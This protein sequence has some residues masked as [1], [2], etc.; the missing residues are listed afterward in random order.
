MTKLSPRD[1][2]KRFQ[3][4]RTTLSKA[5]KDGTISATKTDKGHWKIDAAELS[6]VY[7]PRAT[8]T[9]I[10]RTKPDH[11]DHARPDQ[12]D[13][14]DHDLAARL[15]VAETENQLLREMLDRERETVADLRERLTRAQALIADQ[16]QPQP[17]R[18]WWPW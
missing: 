4:S 1:A 18:K 13:K 10:D 9:P 15:A 12:H 2:V 8:T 11:M 5:I 17:R 7:Q 3:V 16:R 14:P 6:R